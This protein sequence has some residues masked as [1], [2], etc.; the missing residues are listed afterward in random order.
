MNGPSRIGFAVSLVLFLVS[1]SAAA[2]GFVIVKSAHNDTAQ[3]SKGELKEIFTGKTA[4]W[5]NGGKIDLGISPSGSAELKWVA[6]ELFGT[7]DDVLMS[8]IKQEVFKGDM[9]KPTQVTSA[10][11]CFALVKKSAGALCV[12][13]ADSARSL[14]DGVVVLGYPK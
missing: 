14:P 8:K 2:D 9:R 13:D 4:S 12:V 11:E 5:K 1:G 3:A 7:S 10:P 6:Q